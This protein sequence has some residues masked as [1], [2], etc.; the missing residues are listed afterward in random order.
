M[1][2]ETEKLKQI[3]LCKITQQVLA[4]VFYSLEL[5]SYFQWEIFACCCFDILF[6]RSIVDTQ[7]MYC[8]IQELD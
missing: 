7:F 6:V 8:W 5:G 3:L 1:S 4:S 2:G